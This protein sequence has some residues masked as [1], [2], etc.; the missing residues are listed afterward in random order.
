MPLHPL[1]HNELFLLLIQLAVLLA[2]ARVCG[3]V[4]RRM[5]IPAVVGEL[6]AG[7][8]LGPSLLGLFLPD[9]HHALFPVSQL[10][11]DLLSV[12]TW[13]GVIFLLLSTG[14]ETDLPLIRRQGRKAILISGGG[15]LI[16]FVSGL[17]L[18]YYLPDDLLAAAGDRRVFA[19]FVATAMSISAIPVIARV[20]MEL[21]IIRRDIGQ[22][23]LAAGM[24]DDTIGW[25]LLSIVASLAAVGFVSPWVPLRSIAAVIGL[26]IIAFTVGKRVMAVLYRW[27]DDYAKSVD[28][29]IS[30]TIIL[31][32]AAA[33][34]TLK[35]GLE[36]VLGAFVFGIL[37][38]GVPRY[39]P[40]VTRGLE[41]TTRLFFSPIF[42]AV[43]GLKVNLAVF[44]NH[45]LL[46][47]ALVVLAVACMGKFVGAFIGARQAKLGVWEGLAIGAGMNARGA[48][49]IIVATIGLSLGVLSTDMYSIIV[50]VAIATSLMAPP[51]LRL[52]LARVKMGP[53]EAARL[54]QEER[55]RHSFWAGLHRL[56]LPTRGGKNA[57]FAAALV[58]KALADRSVEVT[59]MHLPEKRHRFRFWRSHEANE[60][61]LLVLK[62]AIEALKPLVTRSKTLPTRPSHIARTITQLGEDHDLIV[63]G[64]SEQ[65]ESATTDF[66]FSAVIDAVLYQVSKP[67][68]VVRSPRDGQSLTSELPVLLSIRRILVPT[69]G[70]RIGM[71]A[72]EF[73][74]ALAR[75]MHAECVLLFVEESSVSEEDYLEESG[76]AEG[77]HPLEPGQEE[78]S[79][80]PS[81]V[82]AIRRTVRAARAGY[83]IVEVAAREEFDLIVL[84]AQL[85]PGARGAYLG[86]QVDYVL[87]SASCAVAVLI[88]R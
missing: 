60:A 27:I 19:L 37:L 79:Q 75:A 28:A 9:V 70:T 40:E 46:Y 8:L 1:G 59:V 5:K 13:L 15:I 29:L 62:T 77:F 69:T 41:E 73:G 81:F 56:L 11:S 74:L 63:L 14:L 72:T 57:P 67:V 42:F 55:D 17:A 43:A 23:T 45:Y 76:R 82:R 50:F 87:K 26:L 34:L 2:V 51:L 68:L 65:A 18:G 49:E 48:M 31:V 16:P 86:P 4:C 10:Q 39:R 58:G 83:A 36:A 21:G 53:E 24:I 33:A 78:S 32:L 85:R 6:S 61:A 38:R 80:D 7:V 22:I 71:A 12:V 47:W 44:S 88:T 54:E 84:G 3:G 30:L 35:L 66:T 64:A 25:I 20:L 52:T